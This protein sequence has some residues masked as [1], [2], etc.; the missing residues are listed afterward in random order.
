MRIMKHQ[1]AVQQL[2]Q[3][4]FAE[5]RA[6]NPSFSLR[7]FARKI[8]LSH[9]MTSRVLAG[10]R[11]VSAEVA[12][13]IADSLMLDP[14]EANELLSLFPNKKK[15]PTQTDSVDPMYLQLTADHFK[16]MSDWHYFAILSLIKT[17]DFKNDPTW[18]AQR[19]GIS[20]A[21]VDQAL[22]RLKRLEILVED[23][24]GILRRT[25]PRYRTTD[26][27]VNLS[28]RKAHFTNLELARR[29]L[30]ND[31]VKQRDFSS[32]TLAF[33][34]SRISEAKRAIRKFQDEFDAKF[35]EHERSP[36][37]V[38]RLCINLFP[39]TRAKVT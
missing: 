14:Q 19:L 22:E 24:K 3:H 27:V 30:E 6:K 5:A 28:L 23:K 20:V 37:E 38:Y 17:K 25:V 11:A 8:G 32:L 34:A 29:S 21:T 9:A 39:L 16:L 12:K 1:L 33:R 31:D 10:K 35:E 26:D 7:A 18:I 4:R 15:A 2:L 36:D 13:K